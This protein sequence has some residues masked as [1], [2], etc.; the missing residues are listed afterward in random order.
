MSG[1]GAPETVELPDVT[2]VRVMVIAASWHREIM[3][4]LVAGAE[5]ALTEH[6]V[7]RWK[8]VQV[9]GTVELTAAAA[10]AATKGRADAVVALG[11]VVRGGT[12]HFE[13]VCQSVTA[14]LTEV[15]ART[16]VPVAFGVL[17]C[18]TVEQARDRAGLEGSSEDKGYEATVAALATA[19]VVEQIRT[20][21]F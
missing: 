4:G 7:R 10:M 20:R 11:V 19:K 5:R 1:F 14:G 6:G 13:Y 16:A 18:D 2:D 3:D 15:S 12:P 21:G 9:P 8:L 17:T